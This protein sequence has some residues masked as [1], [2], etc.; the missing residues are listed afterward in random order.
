MSACLKCGGQ[1]FKRDNPGE[2]SCMN[3]GA[4][5]YIED[6]P[7]PKDTLFMVTYLATLRLSKNL[8]RRHMER[9]LLEMP[10]HLGMTRISE[11][12][13]VTH[14][15]SETI[16]A[17]VLIAESHIFL[18]YRKGRRLGFLDIS[19]CK[20]LNTAEIPQYLKWYLGATLIGTPEI[21]SR[22][23]PHYY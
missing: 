16:T 18:E 22:S 11:P 17:A 5:Q 10:G 15:K 4:I 7:E 14:K 21:I 13:I 23:I 6:S 12:I 3:C 20:H 8:W 1:A 19:S 2:R 9:F